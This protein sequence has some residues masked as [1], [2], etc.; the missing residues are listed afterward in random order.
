MDADADGVADAAA[1][2]DG[3]ADA[4]AGARATP[5]AAAG[6]GAGDD[7]GGDDS[8]WAHSS[9]L[10]VRAC[11][12]W[13]ARH[14][15]ERL[16][17]LY[18]TIIDASALELGALR[19]QRGA[20]ARLQAELTLTGD[21]RA[22]TARRLTQSA[23][24]EADAA[25]VH[26]GTS[27]A[28]LWRG[29]RAQIALRVCDGAGADADAECKPLATHPLLVSE[30]PLPCARDPAA[31]ARAESAPL[32]LELALM[33][34]AV[35][36]PAFSF[37]AAAFLAPPAAGAAAAARAAAR[38]LSR[39]TIRVHVAYRP[40]SAREVDETLGAPVAFA[41]AEGDG[42]A[43]R[44]SMWAQ[45]AAPARMFGASRA[46]VSGDAAATTSG[47]Q[48]CLRLKYWDAS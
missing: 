36:A 12:G 30:L 8:A 2:A 7:G 19:K 43:R 1:D 16:G 4:A 47:G 38:A 42:G 45:M 6:S 44:A 32:A 10:I 15:L 34:T 11:R 24:L 37:A 48:L 31:A 39:G 27:Y 5:P 13:A 17:I 9:K 25:A 46:V 26:W 21:R 29:A 41:L 23:P 18:V 14:Q 28:I 35:A 40:L 20:A 22:A 3:V 33:P